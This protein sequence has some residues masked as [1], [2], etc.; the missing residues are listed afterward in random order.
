MR[1]ESPCSRLNQEQEAFTKALP[2][3]DALPDPEVSTVFIRALRKVLA[4]SKMKKTPEANAASTSNTEREFPQLTASKRKANELSSS[5]C[6]PEPASHFPAPGNQFDL[7]PE[8]QDTTGELAATSS[9]KLSMSEGGLP[10]ATVVTSYASP[11]QPSG[12]HK[13]PAMGSDHSEP[14]ASYEA[15]HRRVSW[16]RVRASVWHARWHHFKCPC[17]HQ[18]CPAAERHNKTPIYVSGVVDTRDF[19]SQIRASCPSG[20]TAQ[21]KWEKLML[22]PHTAEGF[23]AT[24]SMLRSPDVGGGMTFHTFSLPEDRCVRL[25]VRNLGRR[26]PEGIVKE[27]LDNFGIRV[28]AI[29]QLRSGRRGQETSN[30]HP[31]TPHFI[32]SVAREPDVARLRCLTELCGLRVSVETYIAPKGPLQCRHCQRFGHT[33]RYCGYAPHCV[34]CGEAHLSGE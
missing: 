11:Q 15:A 2:D 4:A 17:G 1:E 25:L 8:A 6:S 10:Y 33:Q 27:E 31:L 24:V 32:V 19:L 23:R 34:A 20:L 16:R 30:A 13:P 26:M 29:L 3:P 14:A 18:Y 22:V 7:G 21:I 9:R 5:G 28:Q 12:T